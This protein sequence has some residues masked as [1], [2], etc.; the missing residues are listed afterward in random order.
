M[1]IE[2][3]IAKRGSL[4]ESRKPRKTVAPTAD[5]DVQPRNVAR[6]LHPRR[7]RRTETTLCRVMYMVL[8]SVP[9]SHSKHHQVSSRANRRSGRS[10]RRRGSNA[11]GARCSLYDTHTMCNFS[12]LPHPSVGLVIVKVVFSSEK[13]NIRVVRTRFIST[14]FSIVFFILSFSM[15]LLRRLCAVSS[16]FVA[17][18]WKVRLM[19]LIFAV[20]QIQEQI[21]QTTARVDVHIFYRVDSTTEQIVA[22]PQIQKQSVEVIKMIQE[23]NVEVSQVILQE[24]NVEVIKVIF[25]RSSVSKCVFFFRGQYVPHV[26]SDNLSHTRVLVDFDCKRWNLEHVVLDLFSHFTMGKIQW[27]LSAHV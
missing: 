3:C 6:C 9:H 1:K 12:S 4:C 7:P 22:A 25:C 24:Q 21:L 27:S 20:P 5:E 10:A 11:A 23:Q 2:M 15:K 16:L 18:V 8:V 19:H 17:V 14:L 13:W 26:L